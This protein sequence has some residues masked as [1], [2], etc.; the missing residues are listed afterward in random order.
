M[1]DSHSRLSSWVTKSWILS[2]AFWCK[3]GSRTM[4]PLLMSSRCSS[5]CGF[6]KQ[7]IFPPGLMTLKSGGRIF[8]RE[9]KDT[10][11]TARSTCSPMS[12]GTM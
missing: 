6:T 10:S 3:A 1:T 7:M 8:V 11:V 4:P 12:S 9:M 2:M 5:N